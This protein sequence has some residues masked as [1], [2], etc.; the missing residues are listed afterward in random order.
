M[1][2]AV[3]SNLYLL[4][5]KVCRIF[6]SLEISLKVPFSDDFG[7]FWILL[8]KVKVTKYNHALIHFCSPANKNVRDS[9]FP[10]SANTDFELAGAIFCMAQPLAHRG[11]AQEGIFAQWTRK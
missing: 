6:F 3:N 2:F 4:V 5:P 11:Q 7:R 9:R 10:F 1:V 8:F